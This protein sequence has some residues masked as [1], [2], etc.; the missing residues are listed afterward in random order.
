LKKV[1]SKKKAKPSELSELE[2]P[3]E[4]SEPSEQLA[5]YSILLYGEKKIGKTQLSSMFE[6]CFQM[7][8][9]PGGKAVSAYQRPVKG[10]N[11]FKRYVQLLESDTEFQNVSVDTVDILYSMCSA[12]MLDKLGISHPSDEEWGKGWAA[13]RNEFTPWIN[14][15]LNTGKGVIFISH[16]VERE[17]KTRLGRRYD[18]VQTTM[19]GQ[20]SDVLEGIVDI[21]CYLHYE[22]ERRSLTLIGDDHVA[23]GHRL[24][25]RFRYTDGVQIRE[26]DMGETPEQAYSQF[27]S[28]FNN[29]LVNPESEKR[30]KLSRSLKKKKAQRKQR[31]TR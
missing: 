9:E 7:M 3:T 13:V 21:W 16:A 5:D 25:D 1:R 28:A 18:R 29:E 4:R 31:T 15:L 27:I 22:G 20:A 14:R 23:A 10:W 17:V 11:Y 24:K 30:A 19:P 2:L 8:T 6:S 12:H 26:I